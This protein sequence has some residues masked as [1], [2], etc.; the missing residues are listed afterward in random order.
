MVKKILGISCAVLVTLFWVKTVD[1]KEYPWPTGKK[2]AYDCVK[3]GDCDLDIT[4]LKEQPYLF[5]GESHF[6]TNNKVVNIAD[7]GSKIK[8][9]DMIGIWGN[10]ANNES[11][12]E[13]HCGPCDR[14]KWSE[15]LDTVIRSGGG[16]N[17]RSIFLNEKF[18]EEIIDAR[19]L[20]FYRHSIPISYLLQT[21]ELDKVKEGMVKGAEGDWLKI[22]EASRFIYKSSN[23]KDYSS[24]SGSLNWFYPTI[25]P[26]IEAHIVLQ[27]NNV[28]TQ[29]EYELVHNWLEK[30]VWALE[31]GPM[32]GLLSSRWKWKP[33]F[34]SG[35]HETIYKK[36]AYL[37]WGVADQNEDYFTAGLNGFKD[38]H[39]TIR[40][41]GSL[42]GE[43]K[44][45][46]GENYGINSGNKVTQGLIVMS[47]VLH[48]Q[49]YD[50]DKEFP[51]IKRL[52]EYSSKL[53]HQ[54]R[55][56]L[57]KMG[58]GNNNLRFMT[59]DPNYYNTVG[60]MYLYDTVFNTDYAK[61]V[62]YEARGMMM[63][64]IAD[65]GSLN[66]N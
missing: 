10:L 11:I 27:R 41:N 25:L 45:G 7:K 5:I 3:N 4:S 31:H 66:S 20:R 21:G 26:L 62:P 18:K 1:A 36:V 15:D 6:K 39:N 8:P 30:R 59:D 38:F 35:N 16:D 34:E 56:K 44:S 47:V 43:H 65:A 55:S 52:V 37:L 42:K 51:G 32:D 58:G 53:Y 54:P 2:F 28:Y 22:L 12:F 14:F 33:F 40:K 24:Y 46:S 49:G 48:N 64:G 50:I 13:P 60:W 61:D 9:N 63:F 17:D 29:Q 23:A 19:W 57:Q